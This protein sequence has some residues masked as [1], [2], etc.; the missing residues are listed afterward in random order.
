[1]NLMSVFWTGWRKS[2]ID[3]P[4]PS[5]KSIKEQNNQITSLRSEHLNIFYTSSC[6][7]KSV[8][9]LSFE[10]K[11]Q[12]NWDIFGCVMFVVL[13]FLAQAPKTFMLSGE[14][15][16]LSKLMGPYLQAKW[17]T[18]F[19]KEFQLRS[20]FWML[21]EQCCHL[22]ACGESAGWGL[23]LRI[24]HCTNTTPRLQCLRSRWRAC[25][26]VT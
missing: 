5:T 3:Q 21:I 7:I 16:I 8:C 15:S 13:K 4:K 2:G 14:G 25:K 23:L 19:R 12:R 1:M 9:E 6:C 18:S 26:L 22:V 10:Q 17:R 24:P 11:W 20:W